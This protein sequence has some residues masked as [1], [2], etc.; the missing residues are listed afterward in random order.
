MASTYPDDSSAGEPFPT[1]YTCSSS[2]SDTGGTGSHQRTSS[3]GRP[4]PPNCQDQLIDA[5][6]LLASYVAH[7]PLEETSEKGEQQ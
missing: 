2:A 3:T 6:A 5:W 1:P 4:L 7:T